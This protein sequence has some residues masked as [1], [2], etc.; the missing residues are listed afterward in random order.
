MNTLP[1]WITQFALPCEHENPQVFDTIVN[2]HG[3]AMVAKLLQLHGA[4]IYRASPGLRESLESW[5]A[6][7]GPSDTAWDIAFGRLQLAVAQWQAPMQGEAA[8]FDPVDVAAKVGL[9]IAESGHRGAWQMPLSPEAVRIGGWLVAHADRAEV[10][11]LP[12]APARIRVHA[13]GAWHSL[14]RDPADGAWRVAGPGSSGAVAVGTQRLRTVGAQGSVLLLPSRALPP[15]EQSGDI[16]KE[17]QPVDVVDDAAA[18]SF[19]D[20]FALLARNTPQYLPWIERVLHGIVVCPRQVE[21]RLVSG[22]FEDAPG[23][24]HMSSP[25]SGVDIAEVLVHECAHQYFYMLQRVGPVDDAS[26]A[27]LYWSPPIRKQRPLS[28]ILMAYHAL[29]NVQL[30]FDAVRANPANDAQVVDYVR[31][32]EPDLQ[33]AIEALDEPLR[34]NSALTPLGRGLYQPLAERMAQRLQTATA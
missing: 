32:N 8:R 27:T 14:Q 3:V 1:G 15:P 2:T 31:L 4:A 11:N 21:Y 29:A 20:G 5:A 16:F 24:V 19:A 25:H 6:E 22:S 33:A 13:D 10:E 18:Q 7:P 28:R 17:C 9:R 26:D 12:S 34:G 23:L 30:L